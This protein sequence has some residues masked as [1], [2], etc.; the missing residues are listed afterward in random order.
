MGEVGGPAT[1]RPG[2]L[3]RRARG[4]T[5]DA[6]NDQAIL[7]TLATALLIREGGRVTLTSEAWEEAIEHTSTLYVH[8]DEEGEVLVALM[9]EAER[10]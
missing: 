8:R 5:L 2:L 1:Q 3:G 4:R 9:R 10:A 7:A 6:V